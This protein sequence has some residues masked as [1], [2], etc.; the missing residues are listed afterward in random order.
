MNRLAAAVAALLLVPLV[1]PAQAAVQTAAPAYGGVSRAVNVPVNK[2]A[3]FRLDGPVSE[4]VVAQPDIAQ[5]VA[6]TD[7]SFYVR[8][9]ALGGTNILIYDRGRT[10]IEVID[11]HVG[12][13]AGA[14]EA[15]IAQALPGEKIKVR[16]VGKGVTLGGEVSNN[17]A[18]A[19]ARAIA[20]RHVPTA[21]I[22]SAMT[23]LAAEQIQLEVRVLEASRNSLKEL[24]VE[25]TVNNDSG[26][27]FL[28]AP[29]LIGGTAQG[30]ANVVTNSGS[31]RIDATIAAL[32]E[33]GILRTLARPNLTALSGERDRKSVV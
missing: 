25:L 4:V 29:G 7:Q 32:E 14:I 13:D 19:R 1:A 28:T 2:S 15:D 27:V 20:E 30:L 12:H 6:L 17:S 9:K 22:A 23:V 3:A 11:V 33:K 5:I 18:A 31:T 24:G 8:G 16:A 26:F 10:L 21:D